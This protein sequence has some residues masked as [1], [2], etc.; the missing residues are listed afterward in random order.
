M[1]AVAAIEAAFCSRGGAAYL[2][3]AVTMADH[4]L[5]AAAAAV[6]AG[7]PDELVVAALLHDIGHMVGADATTALDAGEDAHHDASGARWLEQWFPRAVT[8]P[9]RLHVAAKRYLVAVEPSYRA[10]L[11]RAS[12]RTLQL[13]GGAMSP[14]EVVAF[15]SSPF[16]ADAV[17]LRRFD[18]AAK[19]ATVV[20]PPFAAYRARI[21][22]LAT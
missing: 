15:E 13:Q 6:G 4:Q 18:E 3:E 1:S 16:H 8:E 9:V 22:S 17:R 10:E 11:S 2:G 14:A 19:D 21:T 5:Q 12:V 7:A 20:V